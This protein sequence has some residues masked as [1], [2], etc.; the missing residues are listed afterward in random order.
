VC[1]WG[2]VCVCVIVNV[3]EMGEWCVHV[4]VCLCVSV[5]VCLSVC[6]C[7]CHSTHI[8]FNFQLYSTCAI[9]SYFTNLLPNSSSEITNF[10][11]PSLGNRKQQQLTILMYFRTKYYSK[12]KSS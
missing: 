5:C 3:R 8:L 11:L 4:S 9:S 7:V 2:E 12:E 6:V 10:D 1:V